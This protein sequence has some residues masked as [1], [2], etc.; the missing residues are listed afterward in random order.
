MFNNVTI[1][2]MPNAGNAA[3]AERNLEDWLSSLLIAIVIIRGVARF[4]HQYRVILAEGNIVDWLQLLR[5]VIDI[6]FE[7]KH[8]AERVINQYHTVLAEG[9][10]EDWLQ[11]LIKLA[12]EVAVDIVRGVA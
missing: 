4:V 9:N 10:L 1:T 3:E 12:I 5:I 8:D 7:I 11:F 2:E 6:V